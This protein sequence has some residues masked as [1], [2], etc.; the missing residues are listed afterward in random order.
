MDV[1]DALFGPH[2]FAAGAV[3]KFH[4][5][6]TYRVDAIIQ[7]RVDASADINPGLDPSARRAFSRGTVDAANTAHIG[8]QPLVPGATIVSGSGS[9]YAYP[10]AGPKLLGS[11]SLDGPFEPVPGAYVDFLNQAVVAPAPSG[12]QQFFRLSGRLGWVIQGASL[13]DGQIRI[14]Y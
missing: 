3:A 4:T 10:D 8:L 9:N 7:G 12:A 13:T 2:H 5:G 11:A 14:R 6:A 1:E